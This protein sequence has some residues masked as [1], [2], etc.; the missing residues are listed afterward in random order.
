LDDISSSYQFHREL[1]SPA[2]FLRREWRSLAVFGGGFVAVL[3]IAV[4]A[5]DPAF[6]YARLGTDSL[7]YYLKGLAFAETGH[8]LAR[9]ALNQTPFQYASMPGVLRSP[10][11]LAFRDFDQQL[12]AIQLFNVALI[13]ATATMYSYV[14]SWTIPKAKHWMAIG[15]TFG[16][17]LLSPVWVA[18]V[19]ATLAEV[20]YAAFSIATFILL[21]RVLAS[22]RPLRTRPFAIVAAAVLFGLAFLVKFTAPLLLVPAA[23]LAAARARQY[24]VPPRVR[25]SVTVAVITVV[26]VLVGLNW[27]SI[28]HRYLSELTGYLFFADKSGMILSLV[29]VALPSQIIPD[30]QLAFAREWMVD[31]YRPLFATTPGDAVVIAAGIA[32][33]LIC[34]FGMWRARR[35]FA[36]EVWYFL[37]VL[38]PLS[39]VIPS[40]SRYLTAYQPFIWIFFFIGASVIFWRT[41][42]RL[43][44]SR[45]APIAGVGLL[46]L[47]TSGLV[48]LRSQRM[49]GTTGNRSASISIGETQNYI[50]EV[51]WTFR[52]L[53]RFLDT[54]PRDRTMLVGGWGMVGRWRVIS[55]LDYFEPDSTLRMAVRESNIYVVLECGTLENCQ[56]F[57]K[58]DAFWRERIGEY[59]NFSFEPV[60]NRT[61][62]HAKT[63]VYRLKNLQ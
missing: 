22:D 7:L 10:F 49:I 62:Q 36:P 28:T 37:A 47:I 51:A 48:Y 35:R 56:D 33:S 41:I 1:E 55:G 32:V 63:K 34:F 25:I 61:T 13:T 46:L 12:R 2:A 60:F 45:L 15:F 54:L 44:A 20:P 18:N 5:V 57:I 27:E 24:G 9:T 58:L 52:G 29:G 42:S 23:V 43:A 30:F 3:L 6:F 11:I 14:L 39:L 21:V 19:F 26:I 8:T 53:R 38:P 40:T 17:I 16:F 31:P 59:G 4:V 50:N